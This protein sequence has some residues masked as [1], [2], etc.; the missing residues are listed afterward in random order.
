MYYRKANIPPLKCM[1]SPKLDLRHS[2]VVRKLGGS[3]ACGGTDHCL[4]SGHQPTG[5]P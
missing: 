1:L 5:S 2:L 3:D 4:R